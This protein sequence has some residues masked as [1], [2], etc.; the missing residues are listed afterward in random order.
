[1]QIVKVNNLEPGQILAKEIYINDGAT[2]LNKGIVLTERYINKLE[3]KGIEQVYIKSKEKKE[4]NEP[5]KAK[6]IALEPNKIVDDTVSMAKS[7][8]NKLNS[9]NQEVDSTEQEKIM[10]L[11]DYLIT[12]IVNSD[13]LI[14]NFQN[15][16]LLEND[17]FSHLSNVLV[18][19]LALGNRLDFDQR[20]LHY[21]GLGAFLHDI[22]KIRVPTKILNKP[23]ELTDEEYEKVKQHTVHGYHML[24]DNENIPEISAKVA[25]QH[26]ENCDGSGYPKGIVKRY[27]NEYSRIVAIVDIFDSMINNR[28]YRDPIKIQEVIE[29][30]YT[31]FTKNKLDKKLLTEFMELITPYPIG[32]KVKLNIGATA[33]VTG[34]NKESSLPLSLSKLRPIVKLLTFESF[35]QDIKLD[36]SQN[37]H[38]TIEKVLS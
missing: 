14:F 27:I 32:T 17:L 31:Q 4:K 1:M 7:Y 21:L 23:G 19:S 22:G 13:E 25:Y 24:K 37:N 18:L 15:I 29:Y 35:N 9:C 16:A 34:I 2:L 6:K 33:I 20:R 36:L 8:V 3:S 11:I 26:H 28:V 10:N 38:I 5:Q 12:K 30:L